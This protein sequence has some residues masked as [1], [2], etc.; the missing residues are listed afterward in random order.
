M[1][2][3][4]APLARSVHSMPGPE[5]VARAGRLGGGGV[6]VVAGGRV[7][8]DVAD[9]GGLQRRDGGGPLPVEPLV[10]V[11]HVRRP[12]R[13]PEVGRDGLDARRDVADVRLGRVVR[14]AVRPVARDRRVHQAC[15][16]VGA[17]GGQVVGAVVRGEHEHAAVEREVVGHAEAPVHRQPVAVAAGVDPLRARARGVAAVLVGHRDLHVRARRHV[18]VER[19]LEQVVD[20]LDA[21]VRDEQPRAP[22]AARVGLGDPPP[23][24]VELDGRAVRVG[25][26]ERHGVGGPVEQRQPS[27]RV[28]RRRPR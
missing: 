2:S 27:V 10:G 21:E 15:V 8:H 24:D 7:E 1:N 11:E 14:D 28:G 5:V 17:Q 6:V 18:A 12:R 26:A 20:R 16:E 4:C 22:R 23:A 3:T 13:R 9:G 19:L 25:A